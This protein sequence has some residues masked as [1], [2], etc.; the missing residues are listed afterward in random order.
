MPEIDTIRTSDHSLIKQRLTR[1]PGTYSIEEMMLALGGQ[2]S[3]FLINYVH[4]RIFKWLQQNS[5]PTWN[6]SGAHMRPL[7]KLSSKSGDHFFNSCLHSTSQTFP[8][9]YL[10]SRFFRFTLPIALTTVSLPICAEMYMISFT[11]CYVSLTKCPL[12]LP[13]YFTLIYSEKYT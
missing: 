7:L 8:L 4:L 5:N 13:V 2:L 12:S 1:F 10:L 6:F 3:N 9:W 11:P